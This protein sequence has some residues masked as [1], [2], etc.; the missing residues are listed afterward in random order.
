MTVTMTTLECAVCSRKYP[1]DIFNPFCK[2]CGNPLLFPPATGKKNFYLDKNFSLERYQEILPLKEINS[3]L[4]LGEG[5]TPLV[6]L[7]RITGEFDL[8]NVLA[9]NETLNPTHSFKDRGTA[10]AV[11]KAVSLGITKIGTVSTGNMASSTAAY[12]ARAGLQTFVLVKEDISKEKLLASCVYDPFIIK[13]KG[14][15]GKL[16]RMSFEI[17]K[18]HNIY[19]MNSTDPFRIEGY[20]I[21]AWE[22]YYQ[23]NK[24]APDYIFVPVSAGGHIIGLMKGF[25]EMMDQGLI[26]RFPFFVGVQAHGCSPLVQAF[27]A[28]L[29]CYER[30]KNSYTIAQSI[31]NPDPPGGNIVLKWI[32]K[33]RGTLIDV[34][35]IEILSARKSLAELEGIFALPASAAALAGL[36]KFNSQ[37][38]I[39]PNKQVVLII[40]GSGL[41]SLKKLSS[42]NNKLYTSTLNKLDHMFQVQLISSSEHSK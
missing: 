27:N 35:D 22:L 13:V 7:K 11:Q 3:N 41:K 33:F 36:L 30:L 25:Q 12:G 32:R 31:S 19:F 39:N 16:Y 6:S 23:L 2:A 28:G 9:K 26:S 24:Q 1:L 20:K 10:I 8:P 15:Y 18:K 21:T 37:K 42:V 14:H 38:Q 5:N 17:G 4:S 29:D 34:T 40:T